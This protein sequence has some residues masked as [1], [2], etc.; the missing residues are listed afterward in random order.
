[1]RV[2]A[3]AMMLATAATAAHAQT[4]ADPTRPPASL[5][6]A[7]AA[8]DKPET[9]SLQ[10]IIR[11]NRGKPAAII[12][13]EYVVLGGRIGD[14]RVVKI[15]EDSVTLK[16][17]SGLETLMLIPGV[18]KVPVTSGGKDA[19]RKRKNPDEKVSK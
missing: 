11:S 3:I 19:A 8:D 5:G 14:A 7:G 9:S 13:G 10:S 16:T 17:A 15:G 18:E 2:Y 4:L 12:N 1:M 6:N